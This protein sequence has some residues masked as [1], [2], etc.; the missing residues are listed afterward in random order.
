MNMNKLI[1]LIL[2][3]SSIFYGQTLN[4]VYH[5]P[6]RGHATSLVYGLD[7][8]I[9]VTGHTSNWC[10]LMVAKIDKNTGREQWV[11]YF[12]G[13]FGRN[14]GIK[15]LF[16]KDSNIYVCGNYK[17]SEGYFDFNIVVISLTREGIERWRYIYNSG[18]TSFW[19]EAYDMVYGED[20]NL[21]LCGEHTFNNTI[22]EEDIIVISLTN[23]G[24]ER[25]VYIY[26]SPID[27]MDIAYDIIY[28]LDG[29]IYLTGISGR[30][31]PP[32]CLDLVVISLTG[33]GNER[34]IYFCSGDFD[35]N[36][37]FGRSIIY[38]DNHLIYITGNLEYYLTG[39]DLVVIALDTNGNEQWVYTYDFRRDYSEWGAEILYGE[40]GNLYVGGRADAPVNPVLSLSNMGEPMWILRRL[41]RVVLFDYEFGRDGNLYG[42]G[43]F[44]DRRIN[45][46]GPFIASLSLDGQIRWLFSLPEP[47]PGQFE[48]L[49]IG[50]DGNLYCCG[51][52]NYVPIVISISP[53]SNISEKDKN[54]KLSFSENGKVYEIDGRLLGKRKISRGIYFVRIKE[55]W[56]KIVKIK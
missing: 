34:W 18:D 31:P 28:G 13:G 6:F 56:Y 12:D 17:G 9:Y 50:D 36:G 47:E 49:T 25:W 35:Y 51:G 44:H 21:Y 11:Y 7:G 41:E 53:M 37:E 43:L 24:E 20:G 45:N 23:E 29:N 42:A 46:N 1:I 3:A 55:K 39:W 22:G 52:V 38:G 5:L 14:E 8:Y 40:N 10:S 16:G 15:I 26:N 27:W 19:D 33:D 32:N 54:L 48:D 4:W 2:T 30:G